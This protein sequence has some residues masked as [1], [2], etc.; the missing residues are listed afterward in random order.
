MFQIPRI[1]S[2]TSPLVFGH[3]WTWTGPRK[4]ALDAYGISSST[5][6]DG[7]CHSLQSASRVDTMQ[8]HT[9]PYSSFGETG[10]VFLA[11]QL[12]RCSAGAIVRL[13]LSPNSRIHRIVEF[14]DSDS[15][16]MAPAEHLQSCRA[17][18]TA[19]VSPNE[20]YGPVCDCIVSTRDA[21]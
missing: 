15:L 3:S 21:D 1:Y 4:I 2:K 5:A 8:S 14:G 12:W 16:T 13:S 20:L 18:K 11:R 17:R 10:A 9:G 6:V 7:T 19:P